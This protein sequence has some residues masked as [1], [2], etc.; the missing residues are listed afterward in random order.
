MC[1]FMGGL[2]TLGGNLRLWL[3][4]TEAVVPEYGWKGEDAC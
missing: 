3:L 1:P 2:I 4:H